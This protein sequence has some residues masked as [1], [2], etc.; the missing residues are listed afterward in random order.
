MSLITCSECGKSFSDKAD[1]CPACGCPTHLQASNLPKNQAEDDL[2]KTTAKK[3]TIID[4][5]LK[6]FLIFAA[7]AIIALSSGLITGSGTNTR[8]N[9]GIWG[10][11]WSSYRYRTESELFTANGILAIGFLIS[12]CGIPAMLRPLVPSRKSLNDIEK[13]EIF[14]LVV[15]QYLN[16]TNTIKGSPNLKNS[17][18]DQDQIIIRNASNEMLCIFKKQETNDSLRK[19]HWLR[20]KS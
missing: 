1:A 10:N 11:Y 3:P 15:P 13:E 20:V 14:N 5:P 8:Y 17:E 18:L 12:I 19:I 2:T 7:G 6:G 16:E 4:S 9:G